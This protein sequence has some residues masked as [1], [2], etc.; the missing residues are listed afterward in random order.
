MIFSVEASSYNF[1]S[2][3]FLFFAFT[4]FRHSLGHCCWCMYCTYTVLN[5][6][7]YVFPIISF[8]T[9]IVV[10]IFRISKIYVQYKVSLIGWD[11]KKAKWF[12]HKKLITR[13]ARVNSHVYVPNQ[14]I[15]TVSHEIQSTT[16][17]PDSV[18]PE[19][20]HIPETENFSPAQ[21]QLTVCFEQSGSRIYRISYIPDSKS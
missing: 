21:K 14:S 4:S 17:I 18:I 11:N 7:N 20:A 15:K 10:S 1:D 19:F 2:E 12:F 13:F 3:R 6:C 8:K 5:S 16:L 9:W